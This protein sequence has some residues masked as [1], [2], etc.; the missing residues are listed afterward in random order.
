VALDY[1]LWFLF[2]LVFKQ[3]IGLAAQYLRTHT[4]VFHKHS[5][6]VNYARF[7]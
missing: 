2:V 1:F 4:S 6:R 5:K 7:H 3:E